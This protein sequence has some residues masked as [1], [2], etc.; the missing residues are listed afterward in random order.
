MW[1]F[2]NLSIVRSSDSVEMSEKDLEVSSPTFYW[3]Y[4]K[5]DYML[6]HL[7]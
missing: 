4:D 7:F 2:I 5:S 6:F 1:L 3:C